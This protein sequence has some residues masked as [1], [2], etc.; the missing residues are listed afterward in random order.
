MTIIG[1]VWIVHFVIKVP[2]FVQIQG[3]YRFHQI[4]KKQKTEYSHDIV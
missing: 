3:G 1:S 4:K 2:K